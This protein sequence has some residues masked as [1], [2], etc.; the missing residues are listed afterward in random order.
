[1]PRL[2]PQIQ[3]QRLS[4]YRLVRMADEAQSETV[5]V[6]ENTNGNKTRTLPEAAKP[7]MW[8]P[9]ES[10]NPGGR[11]KKNDLTDAEKIKKEEA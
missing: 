11:P 6:T 2:W 5:E 7:F 4:W 1:M 3:S 8:K 10:G 9:G